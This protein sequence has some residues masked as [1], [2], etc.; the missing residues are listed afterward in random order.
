M[1]VA[2]YGEA[3]LSPAIPTL[4]D[5]FVDDYVRGDDGRWRFKERHIHRIFVAPDNSGPI[6][7]KR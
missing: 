4:V 7:Q 2:A 6:G 5:D 3:P 1:T